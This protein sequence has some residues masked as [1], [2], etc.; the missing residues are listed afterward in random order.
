MTRKCG[1]CT[2]CCK[3]V[4]VKELDKPA[5]TRCKHQRQF[6]GCL[7]Y[8]SDEMPFSCSLWNCRWLVNNDT[9]DL[10]RPDRSHCVIDIMPDFIIAMENDKKIQIQ[11]V[12][13]WV[14]ANWPDAWKTRA[15]HDYMMR[16]GAEGIASMIRYSSDDAI[17]V[18]PPNMT[19]EKK[20]MVR[21]GDMREK[22]ELNK[23]LMED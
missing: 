4:P 1:D 14:D 9:A 21:S 6:R 19:S 7:V 15:M 20:W 13:I 3:L 11:V 23:L 17:I 12:Q 22:S 8:H 10:S 18:F 2:L 16:R 5:S